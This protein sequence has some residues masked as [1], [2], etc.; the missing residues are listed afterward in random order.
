MNQCCFALLVLHS[1]DPAPQVELVY[2][3]TVAATLL[4]YYNNTLIIPRKPSAAK[5]NAASAPQSGM[6]CLR[7]A[8]LTDME[9]TAIIHGAVPF[10]RRV[11]ILQRL[12]YLTQGEQAALNRLLIRLLC[13]RFH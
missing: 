12:F 8:E 7:D 1:T 5:A 2:W 3:Q 10:E 13:N 4:A 6:C 11:A 9:R